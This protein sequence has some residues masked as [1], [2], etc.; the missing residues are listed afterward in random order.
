MR[1]HFW[2]PERTTYGD[3]PCCDN[4]ERFGK[5]NDT[6]PN[7]ICGRSGWICGSWVEAD[8][9]Q[10]TLDLSNNTVQVDK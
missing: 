2:L 5:K 3:T 7:G 4:C 8:E 9:Q 6:H 1:P 10:I